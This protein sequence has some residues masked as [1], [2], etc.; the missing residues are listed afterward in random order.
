MQTVAGLAAPTLCPLLQSRGAD[1]SLL[2]EEYD[3]YLSP[4]RK[5]PVE[6]AAEDEQVGWAGVCQAGEALCML[7][8]CGARCAAL[9]TRCMPGW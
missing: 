4:G 9:V 3:P 1:P 7:Q 6:V 2:T 8:V 5:L